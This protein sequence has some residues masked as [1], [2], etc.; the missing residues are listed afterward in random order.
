[1]ARG[2]SAEK[3]NHDFVSGCA[4]LLFGR[5]IL[6]F[7]ARFQHLTAFL[8]FVPDTRVFTITQTIAP[9]GIWDV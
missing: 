8:L 5:T 9:M 3:H 1:M 7:F 4:V 6:S 2:D